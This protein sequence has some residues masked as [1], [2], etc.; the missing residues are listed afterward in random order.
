MG[1]G[2]TESD[3]E[4][5]LRRIDLA[6]QTRERART[7]TTQDRERLVRIEVVLQQVLEQ[8]T[9]TNGRLVASEGSIDKLQAFRDGLTA[10]M[11]QRRRWGATAVSLFGLVITALELYQV[12]RGP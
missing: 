7:E 6:D 10:E 12:H 4:R 5:I 9:R 8:A 1:P 11:R 3:I 2:V